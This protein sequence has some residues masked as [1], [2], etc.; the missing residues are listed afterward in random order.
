[1]AGSPQCISGL[2]R[3]GVMSAVTCRA[4]VCIEQARAR[5]VRSGTWCLIWVRWVARRRST[6]QVGWRRT[7]TFEENW[8]GELISGVKAR[9]MAK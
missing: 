5:S 6:D 1:M 2:G 3:E 7:V 4:G 8:L 9:L